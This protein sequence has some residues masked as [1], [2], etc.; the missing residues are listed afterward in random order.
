MKYE[1]RVW[2]NPADVPDDMQPK[3][4][5]DMIQ[6]TVN[7]VNT[8][9]NNAREIITEDNVE[10]NNSNLID[11]LLG[12]DS[13]KA[14]ETPPDI[15]IDQNAGGEDVIKSIEVSYI[16][17]EVEETM[18][19]ESMRAESVSSKNSSILSSFF[20][21][22]I[23]L[24][25]SEDLE[26]EQ[27]IEWN[28]PKETTTK[29]KVRVIKIDIKGNLYLP[30]N[31]NV[32]GDA[33]K[34]A[35]LKKGDENKKRDTLLLSQWAS[36]LPK[37]DN[38]P[39]TKK[40]EGEKKKGL[41]D[42]FEDEADGAMKNAVKKVLPGGAGG[43]KGAGA[44]G[45]EVFHFYRGVIIKI[46]T[47][48][49]D[50]RLITAKNVYVDSYSENYEEGEFG[51]FEMTLL[52]KSDNQDKFKIK[53][54]GREKLSFL[55]KLKKAADPV[56][57]IG[58][59]VTAA[60]AMSKSAVETI[61]MG[62]G[63]TPATRWIKYGLDTTAEAGNVMGSSSKVMKNPKDVNTWM[64]E[65]SNLNKTVNE[66]IQKGVDAEEDI[67]LEKME[68]L[69]LGRIKRDPGKY[70]D[71]LEMSQADKYKALKKASGEILDRAGITR[72]MEEETRDYY[73]NENNKAEDAAKNLS[74]Q[75]DDA[76]NKKN[77]K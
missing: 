25:S 12:E 60:A 4:S 51:T 10:D 24:D 65:G 63:E 13:G 31:G 28:L 14:K 77:G 68:E 49:G 64:K 33:M 72:H 59:G 37:D 26:D 57:D 23:K 58:M 75:I 43:K 55:G 45:G 73:K 2:N 5:A 48:A 39:V 3:G 50:F 27:S 16:T 69:Y 11:N 8:I 6:N 70:A 52:E 74:N 35:G 30:L 61:E 18:R 34:L 41:L 15:L 76:A 56:A 67:P 22:K 7:K 29:R 38:K 40:K 46:M 47:P 9:K 32:G 36:V 54:I 62:I 17:K 42:S 53:G 71:Y 19:A 44:G 66:R 21:S 1:I 20:Q